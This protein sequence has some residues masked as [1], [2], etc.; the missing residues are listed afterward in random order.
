[1]PGKKIESSSN[2]TSPKRRKQDQQK[3]GIA[4]KQTCGLDYSTSHAL[5]AWIEPVEEF[6][7]EEGF[8]R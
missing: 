4:K 3:R 7:Q 2:A 6:V 1:M 8:E 5:D